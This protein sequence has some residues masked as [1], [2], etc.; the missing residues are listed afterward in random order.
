MAASVARKNR[1]RGALLDE[2]AICKIAANEAPPLCGIYFLVKLRQI[3]YVGKS[4]NIRRRVREH[5]AVKDFDSYAYVPCETAM[6]DVLER[7]Y[8]DRFLPQLNIDPKTRRNRRLGIVGSRPASIVK[9]PPP[10]DLGRFNQEWFSP[11]WREKLAECAQEWEE[12]ER[13]YWMRGD[14]MSERMRRLRAMRSDRSLRFEDFGPMPEEG[15][16]RQGSSLGSEESH[17]KTPEC[18][19]IKSSSAT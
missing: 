16:L 7:Q 11:A 18:P 5:A 17:A 14:V 1:D 15:D 12:D 10:F 2:K 3:V 6:L 4:V 9:P 19:A 8:I 13:L